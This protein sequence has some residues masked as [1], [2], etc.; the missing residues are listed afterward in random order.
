MFI[1]Y[2]YFLCVCGYERETHKEARE[3]KLPI[4]VI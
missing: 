2:L 3:R 4:F 1:G